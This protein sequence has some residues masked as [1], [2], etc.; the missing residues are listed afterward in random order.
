MALVGL[1]GVGAQEGAPGG[2]GAWEAALAVSVALPWLC[3]SS[4]HGTAYDHPSSDA[5]LSRGLAGPAA[6]ECLLG[7][8]EDA[9]Q[10]CAWCR[11][12]SMRPHPW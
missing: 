12:L 10:P 7:K 3:C 6:V 4:R 5:H 1:V 2:P 8:H 9:V 11:H